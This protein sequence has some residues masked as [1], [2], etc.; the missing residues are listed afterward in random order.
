M[1]LSSHHRP[2]GGYRNP[3]PLEGQHGLGGAG[4]WVVQRLWRRVLGR[5][6]REPDP[7]TFARA[8]AT[9]HRPR[10]QRDRL[11]ATWIGHSTFLLQVG[12]T[13]VLTDPMWG[14][15][16]SPVGFA[17]PRRWV[18][19]GVAL[20]ALPPIDLVLQSHDHYDHLDRGTV[21]WLAAHHPSAQWCAPR[22]VGVRLRKFGVERVAE[23]DWWEHSSLSGL[24]ILCAPARHFSG[25]GI[26][27]RDATLWCGWGIASAG[28]RVFVAGDTGAHPEFRIIAEHAGP[29]DLVLMPIGAYEPRWFMA[30]VHLS[31]DEAVAA[32]QDIRSVAP[33]G[34]RTVMAGMHWG[35]FKLT[36][37]AMDEPPRRVASEWMRRG[38][39]ADELW[40]PAHGETR[41]IGKDGAG[42]LP[43]PSR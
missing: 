3:W 34:H 32:Y 8:I 27:D 42:L 21:R 17:G 10:A 29:F 36:D 9:I 5:A 31:P 19:P 7:S 33:A 1:V 37:E 39:P 20:A 38:L 12:A 25:R 18:P 6:P 28:H 26:R 40:V 24:D 23:L 22:G 30:P 13:N 14:D 15:R 43:A 4:R 16:A 35:T 11:F 2:G 41:E